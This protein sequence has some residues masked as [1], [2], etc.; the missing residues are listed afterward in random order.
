MALAGS[1][2]LTTS[3]LLRNPTRIM[4]SNYPSITLEKEEYLYLGFRV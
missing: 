3:C 1:G 2:S 4:K